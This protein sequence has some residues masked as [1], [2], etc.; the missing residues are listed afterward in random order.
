MVG[1]VEL[2]KELCK[3]GEWALDGDGPPD[4]RAVGL[5]ETP[6]VVE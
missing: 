2:R 3:L 5:E 1:A 6:V 4:E